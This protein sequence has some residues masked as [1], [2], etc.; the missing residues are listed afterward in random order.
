MT[1]K[2]RL[3]DP[4]TPSNTFE[5][6]G[7][8]ILCFND[9]T[10]RTFRDTYENVK[11]TKTASK[12]YFIE[13]T[14]IWY[15]LIYKD[16]FVYQYSYN[17]T[18]MRRIE[19]IESLSDEQI[20][21]LIKVGVHSGTPSTDSAQNPIYDIWEKN[22]LTALENGSVSVDS[23]K[24]VIYNTTNSPNQQYLGGRWLVGFIKGFTNKYPKY[25]SLIDIQN[26]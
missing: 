6:D 16:L 1:I 5:I 2:Y 19:Q 17:G 7:N 14:K 26:V 11:N 23:I 24:R 10:N 9:N 20:R 18:L 15:Q 4:D 25:M 21:D 12:C 22:L 3:I 13:H 8:S